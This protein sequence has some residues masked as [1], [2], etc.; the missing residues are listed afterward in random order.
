MVTPGKPTRT[1][2]AFCVRGGLLS[3]AQRAVRL[4][5]AAGG[6]TV[7]GEKRELAAHYG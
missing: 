2:Y 6:E 5:L 4:G 7:D 3:P 1:P